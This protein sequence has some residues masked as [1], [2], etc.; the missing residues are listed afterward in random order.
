MEFNEKT[1]LSD[2]L[3]AYP[4]LPDTVAK[5]DKRLEIVNSPLAK[6]LMKRATLKDAGRLSGY[7]VDEIIRE[8]EKLIAEHE[9]R[10]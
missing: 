10:A 3:A 7:P 4:W 2:I 6:T 5:K 9:G 8:L 1:R